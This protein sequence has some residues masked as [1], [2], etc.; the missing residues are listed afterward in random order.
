[1]G[2]YSLKDVVDA[3]SKELKA[4]EAIKAPE[5]VLLVKS[6]SHAQRP[7]QES[8][9]WF[10]RCASILVELYDGVVGVRRLRHK[11]GGKREHW[12]RRAHHRPAGGKAIRVALQQLEK[13]GL[14]KKEKVGRSIS[15]QGK[16]IVEKTIAGLVA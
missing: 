14:A 11:Y 13:A 2:A 12:V 4:F 8:D 9:F 7:P 3:L 15:A 1:M 6:G 16:S 10:K 5:W